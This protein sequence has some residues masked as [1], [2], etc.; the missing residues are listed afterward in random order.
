MTEI[1]QLTQLHQPEFL[2]TSRSQITK[3]PHNSWCHLWSF[4]STSDNHIIL[5]FKCSFFFF[6]CNIYAQVNMWKDTTVPSIYISGSIQTENNKWKVGAPICPT[7]NTRVYFIQPERQ[8]NS[9]FA[10]SFCPIKADQRWRGKN[11]GSNGCCS[12]MSLKT[13]F[14]NNWWLSIRRGSK[15]PFPIWAT[16]HRKQNIQSS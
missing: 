14:L 6:K 5:Q 2:Y 15:V 3:N 9:S 12:Y 1:G 8:W 10:K 13:N 16:I 7:A 4:R 11:C